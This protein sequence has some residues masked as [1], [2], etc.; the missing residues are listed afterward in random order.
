MTPRVALIIAVLVLVRSESSAQTTGS[1]LTRLITL[2]EAVALALEHN[3]VVRLSR[4]DVQ[5]HEQVQQVARSA[6]F[7]SVRNDTNTAHVSDTQLIEIPAGGFGTVGSAL[8]PP[9]SIIVNQ[10]GTSFASTGF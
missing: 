7:P 6:Y 8:V 10:G 5:E 3:H 2:R 9:H 4:L 1:Q